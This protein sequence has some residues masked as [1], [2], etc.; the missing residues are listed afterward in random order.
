MLNFNHQIHGSIK[1][2]GDWV[3]KILIYLDG[4]P[5]VM[6]M[7]KPGTHWN[8]PILG[9]GSICMEGCLGA[10]S[11]ANETQKNGSSP[12]DCSQEK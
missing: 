4:E 5:Q 2:N 8:L 6:M 7:Q 11:R 12:V 9:Y 1:L 3:P 10:Y